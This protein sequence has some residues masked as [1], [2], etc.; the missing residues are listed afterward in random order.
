[1]SIRSV[2]LPDCRAYVNLLFCIP[3]VELFGKRSFHA[4]PLGFCF[5]SGICGSGT[6]TV[7]DFDCSKGDRVRVDTSAGNEMFLSMLG[8]A[9][10]NDNGNVQILNAN[11]AIEI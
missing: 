11:G 8:L 5:W 6:T 4:C 7:T 3:L 1:M 10:Q 9:V 2:F